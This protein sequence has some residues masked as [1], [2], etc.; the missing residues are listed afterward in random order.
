MDNEQV[1]IFERVQVR[2]AGRRV[3]MVQKSQG[4]MYIFSTKRNAENG[5]KKR[6]DI[7]TCPITALIFTP[8]W[9]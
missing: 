1:E 8:F 6:F 5:K 9:H 4:Y 3:V 7:N 2:F